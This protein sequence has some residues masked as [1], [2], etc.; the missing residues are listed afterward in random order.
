MMPDDYWN[1][2]FKKYLCRFMSIVIKYVYIGILFLVLWPYVDYCLF[3]SKLFWLKSFDLP[4][5]KPLMILIV[6]INKK[7]NILYFKASWQVLVWLDRDVLN[8]VLFF[9]FVRML[10]CFLFCFVLHNPA[11]VIMDSRFVT[12]YNQIVTSPFDF[13]FSKYRLN[14]IFLW[15]RTPPFFAVTLCF[16]L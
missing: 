13:F 12:V 16:I 9:I 5:H 3:I 4:S 11:A 15:L 10:G 1:M 6:R 2:L 7:V 14:L 8:I